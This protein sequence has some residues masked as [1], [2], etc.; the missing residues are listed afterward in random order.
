MSAPS[1]AVR[2]GIGIRTAMKLTPPADN[3]GARH[4][5]ACQCVFA[6]YDLNYTLPIITICLCFHISGSKG[7]GAFVGKLSNRVD[8]SIYE[9]I[10]GC[11]LPVPLASI[12]R[13]DQR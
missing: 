5:V 12:T 8:Q 10:H 7:G 13:R 2:V 3:A 9:P 6:V 4:S 1:L 11:L